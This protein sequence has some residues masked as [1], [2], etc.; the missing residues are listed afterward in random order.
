MGIERYLPLLTIMMEKDTVEEE[1][2]AEN[3]NGNISVQ[4]SVLK[5][6]FQSI[7]NGSSSC[8]F[9]NSS[10]QS[11]LTTLQI[12]KLITPLGLY[13]FLFKYIHNTKTGEEGE[14]ITTSSYWWLV[15]KRFLQVHLE[16]DTSD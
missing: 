2:I 6:L 11:L 16:E 13:T 10:I 5:I 7:N 12:G 3:T 4:Q 15:V 1:S 8:K 9:Y 14:I